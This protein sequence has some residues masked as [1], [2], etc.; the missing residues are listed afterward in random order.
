MMATASLTIPY[1]KMIENILGNLIESI[2]V[3]AATE[4]VADIVALYLTI[5]PVYNLTISLS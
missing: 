5:N 3:S 1:P 4:S 2:S